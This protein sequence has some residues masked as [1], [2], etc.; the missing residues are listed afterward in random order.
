MA[1]RLS[2]LLFLV[3]AGA[4]GP[5]KAPLKVEVEYVGCKSVLMP[6]PVCVPDPLKGLWL[7]VDAPPEA[8]VEIR[9]GGSRIGKEVQPARGGRRF[10]MAFPKRA[11]RLDVLVESAGRR[12]VWSLALLPQVQQAR[13]ETSRDVR[14]EVRKETDLVYADILAGRLPAARARLDRLLLPAGTDAESRCRVAYHRG[15]LAGAEGD[16]RTALAEVGRALEIAERVLMERYRWLLEQEQALLLRGMGRS[17][18]AA[19]IFERLGRDP[20]AKDS[21]LADFLNNWGW[22]ALLD[23]EAGGAVTDPS[24]LFEK[25]LEKYKAR[26]SPEDEANVL[27][28]LALARLQDGRLA[29]SRGFLAEARELVL[30]PPLSHIQWRLDLEARMALREGRPRAALAQFDRLDQLARSA[31]SPEA[32][33]RA[34]LG[35]ARSQVALA[36]PAAALETLRDAEILLDRQSLHIR[37]DQGRETFMADRQAL[38]GLHL[39]ILLDQ[40]RNEEALAVARRARSRVLVQLARAG[41]LES[42]S[43]DQ[44][45][46]WDVLL[47]EYQKRRTVL[48]EQARNDWKL[49]ADRLPSAW[50]AREA[51]SEKVQQ[52]LDEAFQLLEDAGGRSPEA[53]PAPPRPGELILA[54]HPLPRG[55]AGFAWDGKTVQAARF[56]LPPAVLAQPRDLKELSRRLLLPFRDRIGWAKRLRILPTGDLNA[57]DFQALPF[58]GGVLLAGRPVV[59]GLDLPVAAVPTRSPGRHA[60]IVA[61]PTGDLPGSLDE[62][63]EVA[64]ALKPAWTLEE[65]KDEAASAKA[66]WN[67]LPAADLLHYAGH[68]DFSGFGGWESGLRLAGK[69]RLKLGDFLTLERDRVPAWVILSSC[70]TGRTSADIPVQGL[71]LAHAFL[72]AGSRSVIASTRPAGDRQIP[73]FFAEL[74][75]QWEREPD[76]AMAL[77]RAELDWRQRDPR[78]DWASFRLFEP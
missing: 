13:L 4:C 55:W 8:R 70:D 47:A 57:V 71:G 74:Y 17:R 75:R 54:Y 52:I 30:H 6:G 32:R 3:L 67:R 18:E 42:L 39:Q 51:E 60:L 49:P 20:R 22:S 25:A 61:N 14:G 56:D 28:N 1:R 7:W 2:G 31:G 46:R 69:T 50:A 40:G 33:L 53:P 77:Q 5:S 12:G 36:D 35:R 63:R 26:K 48:E 65:L 15:L 11:E 41:R 64:R 58:G 34:A 59:Y 43:P 10:G 21:D 62:A 23:R 72:L 27:L 9:A 38:V 16:Y 45:N 37:V 29:E 19:E 68:G 24:G 66:V 44:R 76:L 78:A 73:A